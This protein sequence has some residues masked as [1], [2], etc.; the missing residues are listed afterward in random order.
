MSSLLKVQAGTLLVWWSYCHL[1][2]TF[3][4]RRG[5]ELHAPIPF[6]KWG[7][8][9]CGNEKSIVEAVK[10]STQVRAWD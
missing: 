5:K 3:A 2:V 7:H 1:V 9:A 8:V 10:L 4:L 6:N